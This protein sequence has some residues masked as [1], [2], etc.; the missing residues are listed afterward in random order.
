[1]LL[2]VTWHMQLMLLQMCI[3]YCDAGFTPLWRL[4]S[5]SRSCHCVVLLS[6]TMLSFGVEATPS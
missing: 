5:G 3:T 2:S 4:C 6:L 1:M